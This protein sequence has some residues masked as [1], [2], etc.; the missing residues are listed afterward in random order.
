MYRG[1]IDRGREPQRLR[2]AEAVN[3]ADP[4]Q[5]RGSEG[6]GARLVEDHGTRVAEPFDHTAALDDDAD[7]RCS[8]DAREQGDRRGKDQRAGVATT[9]TV[10]ARTGSPDTAQATA[11][12]TAVSGRKRAA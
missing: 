8:R 1:E 10:S 12:T 2:L 11:A 6:D 7:P 3:A 9:N 4:S 5:L